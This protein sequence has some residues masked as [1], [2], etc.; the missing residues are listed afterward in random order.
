MIEIKDLLFR[1]S[2]Y[3]DVVLTEYYSYLNLNKQHVLKSIRFAN[4]YNIS[5]EYSVKNMNI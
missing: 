5:D 1:D 3:Q 2:E 4:A